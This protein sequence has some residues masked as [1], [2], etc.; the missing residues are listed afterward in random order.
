MLARLETQKAILEFAADLIGKIPGPILEIGLG[1]GRTWSH[2][3]LLFPGRRIIV[4]D[5][6]VHAP[7]AGTPDPEDLVLGEFAE[8]LPVFRPPSP[9]AFVHADFGSEDPIQD[10]ETASVI[11]AALPPM[12]ARQ[13]IVAADRE[14]S[15]P[16]LEN[17][18]FK[19][20]G[21]PYF[22]YKALRG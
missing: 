5:R 8:T 14:L 19:N 11:A 13:G 22:L 6:D 21:F 15:I 10:Q 3:R 18:S 9:A 2:L 7:A 4:F 1:K 12:L 16:K 20:N 17:I